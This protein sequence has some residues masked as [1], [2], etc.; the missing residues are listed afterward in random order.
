MAE[1]LVQFAS[2]SLR[3]V[4]SKPRFRKLAKHPDYAH[5]ALRGALECKGLWRLENT[6]LKK[7]V[8][9]LWM[10]PWRGFF[11]AEGFNQDGRGAGSILVLGRARA[12]PTN[13]A[14]HITVAFSFPGSRS[15]RF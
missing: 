14:D 8:P 11:F 9:V 1:P 3:P 15:K 12:Q 4:L 2:A 10:L 5:L 6:L 7:S 13:S